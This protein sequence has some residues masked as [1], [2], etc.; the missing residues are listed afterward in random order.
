[1]DPASGSARGGRR[2][3]LALAIVSLALIAYFG[4]H[5]LGDLRRIERATL[6][7]L[8][9]ILVLY[10]AARSVSGEVMRLTLG[11]LG[12]QI[13]RSEAFMLTMLVS[14][15]NL[16]LPR[17][18]YGPAALYLKR[19]YGVPLADFSSLLLPV[20]AIQLPCIGALGLICQA[21]LAAQGGIAYDPAASL[22]FAARMTVGIAIPLLRVPIPGERTGRVASFLRR[23]GESWRVLAS[24]ARTIR[25]MVAC[26]LG[27]LL[28]RAVRLELAF[29]ALDQDPSFWGV[30]VASLLADVVFLLSLTPAALGLREAVIAY[31]AE[32]LGIPASMAVAVSIL[33]RLTCTLGVVVA[34]QLSLWRLRAGSG[35]RAPV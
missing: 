35:K 30:C 10:F 25:I 33:D 5:Y 12:H 15:T 18:G 6:P 3:R 27:V 1:M 11:K 17:A 26:Q 4:R 21:V 23:F 8:P 22:V 14:Y 34:G 28:L 7:L 32:A 20:I 24:S 19:R 2:I 16:A 29:V 9:V 31:S 13:R